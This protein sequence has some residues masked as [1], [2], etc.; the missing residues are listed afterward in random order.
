LPQTKRSGGVIVSHPSRCWVV[1]RTCKFHVFCFVVVPPYVDN[2]RVSRPM[3]MSH[4]DLYDRSH[5]VLW[6]ACSGSAVSFLRERL[7]LIVTPA[8]QTGSVKICLADFLGSLIT[9]TIV[10]PESLP[11][12]QVRQTLRTCLENLYLHPLT[13]KFV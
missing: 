7:R 5:R 13:I 4:C 1:H 12:Y 3:P 6:L 8:I 9:F 2:G 11:Y 10:R